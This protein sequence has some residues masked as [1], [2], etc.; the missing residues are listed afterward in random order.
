MIGFT[1]LQ[2]LTTARCLISFFSV[3]ARAGDLVSESVENISTVFPFVSAVV[4]T[5]TPRWT[6]IGVAIIYTVT[7]HTAKDIQFRACVKFGISNSR[8]KY[9]VMVVYLSELV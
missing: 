9:S 8:Y 6:D 5:H 2:L 4:D 3:D 7:I 1:V